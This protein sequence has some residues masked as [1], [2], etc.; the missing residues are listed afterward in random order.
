MLSLPTIALLYSLLL[1]LLLLLQILSSK[2]NK[3]PSLSYPPSPPSLPIIGHLHLLKPLLHQAF[4]DLSQ[5]Y[6]PLIFLKIDS[7]RFV[8]AS[9]PSLAKEFI[10]LNEL[11]YSSRNMNMAID[12][13]TY[14]D[15]SFAFAE[16]SCDFSPFER[17]KSMNSIKSSGTDHGQA[18]EARVLAR[19]VTDLWRA[20]YFRFHRNL[21]GV[22]FAGFQEESH[23]DT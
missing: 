20:Q 22:G 13:V 9:N 2:R 11:A 19:E 12:I 14:H 4:K 7:A 10:K 16:L 15:S 1:L 5:K 21:E 18:E 17:G 8:V 3:S 23:L 6:G